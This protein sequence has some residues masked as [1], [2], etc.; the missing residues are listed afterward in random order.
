MPGRLSKNDRQYA[1]RTPKQMRRR[2]CPRCGGIPCDGPQCKTVEAKRDDRLIAS[3]G[4]LGSASSKSKKKTTPKMSK[5]K[6]IKTLKNKGLSDKDIKKSL[7]AAGY[8]T[9][10]FGKY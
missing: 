10:W 1:V 5:A 6:Y 3:H 4:G 9:S 7:K 2:M 8:P